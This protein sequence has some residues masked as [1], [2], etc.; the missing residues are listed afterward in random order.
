MHLKS[1]CAPQDFAVHSRISDAQQDFKYIHMLY[2]TCG[3][4]CTAGF[5]SEILRCTAGF[6]IMASL[7][8]H[9]HAIYGMWIDVHSRISCEILLCC[10]S[11]ILLCTAGFRGIIHMDSLKR[12]VSCCSCPGLLFYLRY[13]RDL[14]L[15]RGYGSVRSRVDNMEN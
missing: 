13:T 6:R 2:M 12:E 14:G 4:M 9:P 15:V 7:I 3:L 11:E 1:C 10:R 5:Q 8:Q